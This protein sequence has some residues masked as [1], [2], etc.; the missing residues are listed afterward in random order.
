MEDLIAVGPFRA[1][2]RGDF[3]VIVD[4]N[5]AVFGTFHGEWAHHDVPR[6]AE[7][8]TRARAVADSLSDELDEARGE[9]E[10]LRSDLRNAEDAS[11]RHWRDYE[12]ARKERDDAREERD[13][14]RSMLDDERAR[15]AELVDEIA[16]LR[17]AA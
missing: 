16:G 12:A 15:V 17:G 5:G 10:S 6:I 3:W 4:G 2:Q 7:A 11:D 8:M 13:E 9:V 1:E 14:L